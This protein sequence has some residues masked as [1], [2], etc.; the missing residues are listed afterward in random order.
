MDAANRLGGDAAQ[1]QLDAAANGIFAAIEALVP[2]NN[3]QKADRSRL[4][5]ALSAAQSLKQSDYTDLT[6]DAL[7]KAVKE[8]L[9]LPEDATQQEVDAAAKAVFD[10]L[11]ALVRRGGSSEDPGKD[12]PGSNTP[13]G[14]GNPVLPLALLAMLSCA[15]VV[16][17][18]RAKK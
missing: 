2:L 15:G 4:S 16:L 11:Q 17:L 1:A 12:E 3:P 10:S 7:Q 6:W 18:R 9:A 5:A 13:T 14:D 8:A